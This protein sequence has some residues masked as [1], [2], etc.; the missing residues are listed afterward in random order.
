MLTRR[1][2]PDTFRE[3]VRTYMKRFTTLMVSA[4]ALAMTTAA[5]TAPAPVLLQVS[6]VQV[7]PDRA[8]EYREIEGKYTEAYKKG[9][10]TLRAVYQGAAGNPYEYLIVTA[11]P[12][13]AAMDG[14]SVYVKGSTA[15]AIAALGARRNQCTTSVNVTYERPIDVGLTDN[16]AVASAKVFG[17]NRVQVRPGM[18]DDYIAFVKNELVPAL[19]KGG[20][21]DFRVRRVE[22]GGSR[23][24]F[25]TRR[26]VAN[27][28]EL[29]GGSPIEKALGKDGSAAL[30]KKS[31]ALATTQYFLYRMR[32]EISL[33]MP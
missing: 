15:A 32:P 26:A 4:T 27:F 10:G 19:K 1:P 18:A 23:D 6:R 25:T 22:W 16:A 28:A 31:R 2:I 7:K 29:D 12:N 30:L 3:K 20:V 17:V 21:K 14:E 9:G 5:Q 13:F 11:M 33:S 24:V 8:T